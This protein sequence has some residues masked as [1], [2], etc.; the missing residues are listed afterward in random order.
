MDQKVCPFCSQS[1]RCLGRHLA[2]VLIDT[3]SPTMAQKSGKSSL[4]HHYPN[5]LKKCSTC[6]SAFKWLDVH[7]CWNAACRDLLVDKS[8]LNPQLPQPQHRQLSRD[9]KPAQQQQP[10]LAATIYH[11][12][13]TCTTHQKFPIM[14]P[15][16]ESS[17]PQINPPHPQLKPALKLLPSNAIDDWAK[18]SCS[19]NVSFPEHI[20][21]S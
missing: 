9:A 10:T 1:F 15:S 11:D 13:P 3:I 12:E 14:H 8:Y 5:P 21:P 4:T 6:G 18:T 7:F 17:V 19:R 2:I 20:T 16:F